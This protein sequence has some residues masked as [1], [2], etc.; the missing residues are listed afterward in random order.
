MKNIYVLILLTGLI[1]SCSQM[2]KHFDREP[3]AEKGKALN[4]VNQCGEIKYSENNNVARDEDDIMYSLSL[5]CNRDKIIDEQDRGLV[6]GIPLEQL[7]PQQKA[8]LTRWKR[9]AVQSAKDLNANPYLCLQVNATEDPC[10][11]GRSV[12]GTKPVFTSK[13][14]N[15]KQN[16]L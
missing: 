2:Q 11:S 7:K 3:S 14:Y 8:W 1:L 5:D 16:G 4:A 15:L 10:I 9:Q 12:L 13:I 6:I